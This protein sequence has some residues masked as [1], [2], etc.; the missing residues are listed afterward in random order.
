[1][2]GNQRNGSAPSTISIST[3][4]WPDFGQVNGDEDFAASMSIWDGDDVTLEMLT[5]AED[6]YVDEE[7]SMLGDTSV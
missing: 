1:M 3:P 6:E 2:S 4:P 7:V 5:E